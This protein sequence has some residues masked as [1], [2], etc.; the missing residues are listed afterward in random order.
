MSGDFNLTRISFPIRCMSPQSVLM[1]TTGFATTLPI[2]MNRAATITDPVE[3][4]KLVMTSNFSWYL[5]NQVFH[6]PLNPILGETYQCIG[7]DGARIFLEQTAHHPPRSHIYV[8][9]PDGLYTMNGWM[10]YE[11]YAGVQN[12]DVKCHG[13]K[14]VEFADGS[15]IK[16]NLNSDHI[17]G[18]VFGTMIH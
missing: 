6:K 8:D 3:R 15:R 7:Q 10:E 2:Y 13:F 4:M 12:S 17:G 11:I 9:G 1:Q 5:Y 16:W 14:Q 18:V